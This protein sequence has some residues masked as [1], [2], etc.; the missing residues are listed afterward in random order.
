MKRLRVHEFAKFAGVGEHTV[1]GWIRREKISPEVTYIGLKK[2][3]LI[4]ESELAKIKAL[5]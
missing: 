1:Y 4:P 2:I 5:Q 3:I